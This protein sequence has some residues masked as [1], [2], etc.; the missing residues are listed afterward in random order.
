[1]LL[2][3]L[4]V[5]DSPASHYAFGIIMTQKPF[6]LCFRCFCFPISVYKK[7]RDK[8]VW[9]HSLSHAGKKGDADRMQT[10]KTGSKSMLITVYQKITH[11]LTDL[12][13]DQCRRRRRKWE[14]YGLMFIFCV[15]PFAFSVSVFFFLIVTC[16]C[17]C[18]QMRAWS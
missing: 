4:D 6:T 7:K 5:V 17:N 11:D 14:S 16:E 1:M 2:F 18:K 12:D 9:S 3:P 15:P 10:V 8:N 13:I